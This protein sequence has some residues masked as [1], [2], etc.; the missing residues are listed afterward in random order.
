MHSKT[1]PAIGAPGIWVRQRRKEQAS[2]GAGGQDGVPPDKPGHWSRCCPRHGR[3]LRPSHG[4]Q[5]GSPSRAAVRRQPCCGS[6]GGQCGG[7]AVEGVQ[8]PA[9]DHRGA[10]PARRVPGGRPHAALLAR[11]VPGQQVSCCSGHQHLLSIWNCTRCPCAACTSYGRA[12]ETCPLMMAALARHTVAPSPQMCRS[13]YP[14]QRGSDCQLSF[15]P[16]LYPAE[17]ECGW[18]VDSL[19]LPGQEAVKRAFLDTQ[20]LQV[21]VSARPSLAG[22]WHTAAGAAAP[23]G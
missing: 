12:E 5:P 13:P 22:H 6:G 17:Q 3:P 16:G 21:Q 23:A 10:H 14:P 18:H 8:G 4:R 20:W 1:T 2:P 11:H 9:R 7:P 15:C 19:Q